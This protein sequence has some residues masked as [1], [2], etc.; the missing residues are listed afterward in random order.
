MV[1]KDNLINLLFPLPIPV[2]ARSK[3]YEC[4]CWLAGVAG[5]N[6]VRGPDDCL[7]CCVLSGRDFC[8][9]LVTRLEES[10]RL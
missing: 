1:K 8:F 10:Y 2:A 5:S 4:G 9:E 3:D 6:P 7:E